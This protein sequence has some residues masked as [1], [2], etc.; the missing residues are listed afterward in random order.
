MSATN[1][2]PGCPR[3][4]LSSPP[5][6]DCTCL[7]GASIQYL[8]SPITTITRSSSWT[9]SPAEAETIE[10]FEQ[11]VAD[12]RVRV[13]AYDQPFNYSALNNYA[14][15]QTSGELV[16]LINNDIEVISPCWLR[17]MA[18]HAIRPKIGAVGAMLYY[19][20]NTIQHAGVVLGLGGVAGHVHGG[21]PR[22]YIGQMGRAQLTQ[23]LQCRHRRMP[24]DTPLGVRTG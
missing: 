14:V 10:Y 19:P 8:R 11:V 12:P 7:S 9:T 21:H 2:R 23:N 13:L 5:A 18:G 6:M 17:E 22:G 4:A 20:D 1:D 15:R 24:L 16:G 3:S